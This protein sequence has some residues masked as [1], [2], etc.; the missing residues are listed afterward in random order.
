M[1]LIAVTCILSFCFVQMHC[2][3]RG[4][5]PLPP[6]A[7]KYKVLLDPNEYYQSDEPHTEVPPIEEHE[8]EPSAHIV[9]A[10]HH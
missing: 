4:P 10:P 7:D 1:K 6:P 3:K 9:S 2:V 5:P 8:T